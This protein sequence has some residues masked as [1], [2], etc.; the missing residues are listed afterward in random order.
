MSLPEPELDELY[1]EIIFDHYRHPRNKGPLPGAT[2]SLLRDNPF[3]GDEITLHLAVADG[4]AREVRYEGRGCSISQSSVSI[5]TEMVKGRTLA[6][7]RQ[8]A[9][10]FRRLMQGQ[11]DAGSWEQLGDLE[12][13]SGVVKFPVRVKCATLAWNTLLEAL[14]ELRAHS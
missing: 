10:T 14:K 12:A 7:A 2:V 6:E 3:C 9:E 13:L 11:A 1:R 8:L 4:V 5:M